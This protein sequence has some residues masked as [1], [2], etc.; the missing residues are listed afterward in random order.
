MSY[1]RMLHDHHPIPRHQSCG[2]HLLLME[3]LV[4][5]LRPLL[6]LL[7]NRSWS[8]TL[9]PIVP[10]R[11]HLALV[12]PQRSTLPSLPQWTNPRKIRRKAKARVN[13][14]PQNTVLPSCPLV[15]LH[16]KSLSIHASFARRITIP[17]IVSDDLKLVVCSEGPQLS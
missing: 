13:P 4:Q 8:Q 2:L 11:I 7:P 10:P 1:Y 12:K 9:L 14:M 6:N 17:R 16:N 3:S 5:C 15:I